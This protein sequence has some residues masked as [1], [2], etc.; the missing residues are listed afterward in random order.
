MEDFFKCHS[1]LKIYSTEMQNLELLAFKAYKIP[2]IGLTEIITAVAVMLIRTFKC[3]HM[4]LKH[5]LKVLCIQFENQ[6]QYQDLV[7]KNIS[8]LGLTHFNS[9]TDQSNYIIFNI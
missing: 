3:G 7:L 8:V 6:T 5:L 1:I 4:S 9:K 2:S